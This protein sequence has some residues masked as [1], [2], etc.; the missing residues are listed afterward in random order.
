MSFFY[1]SVGSKFW[2]RGT[3]GRNGSVIRNP[4]KSQTRK[5]SQSEHWRKVSFERLSSQR[6]CLSFHSTSFLVNC[7]NLT[8][9]DKLLPSHLSHVVPVGAANTGTHLSPWTRGLSK[10]CCDNWRLLLI[11]FYWGEVYFQ[12]AKLWKYEWL[13]TT[14]Q[15]QGKKEASM[16]E[17]VMG[18]AS[19][20]HP[21][22][23]TLIPIYKVSILTFM[24]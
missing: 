22:P 8:L 20:W 2:V 9:L 21:V 24:D 3:N 1:F 15:A 13:V 6:Q 10:P 11:I 19:W 23:V 7:G 17:K 16:Q 12:V 18:K 4:H 14:S 5:Q